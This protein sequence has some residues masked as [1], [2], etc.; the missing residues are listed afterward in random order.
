[1]MYHRAWFMW[2]SRSNLWLMPGQQC[3]NWATFPAP[4]LGFVLLCPDLSLLSYPPILLF[5]VGDVYTVALYIGNMWPFLLIRPHNYKFVI[6][7]TFAECCNDDNGLFEVGMSIF[8]I[9]SWP[10]AD[11]AGGWILWFKCKMFP[12]CSFAFAMLGPVLWC[13]FCVKTFRKWI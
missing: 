13:L 3:F 6:H 1:M 7:W 2:S 9:M 8:C 11:G 5:G 4:L 10:L 12:T